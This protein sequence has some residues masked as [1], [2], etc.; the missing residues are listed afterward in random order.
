MIR[1]VILTNRKDLYIHRAAA[2]LSNLYGWGHLT[3]FDDSGDQDWRRKMMGLGGYSNFIPIADEPVGYSA[4]MRAIWKWCR[5]HGD[6]VLFWEEDFILDDKL[7]LT[8]LEAILDA[9]PTLAQVALQRQPWY[10]NEKQHGLIGAQRVSGRTF[11]DMGGWIKH[12]SGFTTNPSLINPAVFEHEWP[13]GEW[14]EFQM[15]NKLRDA[16]FTFAYYGHEGEQYVT[17]IGYERADTSGGY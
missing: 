6:R 10:A 7:D 14:T 2:S 13:H 1:V 12:D 15:S 3:I 5:D 8:N 16:G 17:H 9:D 4:A 11:V